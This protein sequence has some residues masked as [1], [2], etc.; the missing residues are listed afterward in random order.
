MRSVAFT[1]YNF[2]CA[3]RSLK[4][5][6]HEIF[7]FKFFHESV[8]PKPLSIP[9]G[10][11]EFFLKDLRKYSQLKVHHQ[12]RRWHRGANLLPVSL[13]PVANCHWCHWHRRK[14]WHWR[15]I[16]LRRQIWHRQQI[17]LRYHWLWWQIYK[18]GHKCFLKFTNRKSA[19][20]SAQFAYENLQISESCEFENFI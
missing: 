13:I 19:N 9:F 17:C 6:C 7:D 20:S 14:I 15:Q 12:R 3:K 2:V 18:D 8:S 1:M 10:P 5:Q 11:F 16:L 4:G